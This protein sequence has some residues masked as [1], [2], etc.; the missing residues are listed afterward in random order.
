MSFAI[1]NHLS[2][3]GLLI[4]LEFLLSQEFYQFIPSGFQLIPLSSVSV[5]ISAWVS[6]FVTIDWRFSFCVLYTPWWWRAHPRKCFLSAPNFLFQRRTEFWPLTGLF[7]I[8]VTRSFTSS[9]DSQLS[10]SLNCFACPIKDGSPVSKSNRVWSETPL[11]S[12]CTVTI[13]YLNSHSVVI[14]TLSSFS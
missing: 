12:A 11:S 9:W 8:S 13:G 7:Q 10:S 6:R 3:F 2:Q 4:I 5:L 14:R 1:C